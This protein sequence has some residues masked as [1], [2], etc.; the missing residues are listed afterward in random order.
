LSW[1]SKVANGYSWAVN[2]LFTDGVN[3]TAIGGDS[4]NILVQNDVVPGPYTGTGTWDTERQSVSFT[5]P[6]APNSTNTC[7]EIVFV[8]DDVTGGDQNVFIQLADVKLERGNVATP[9]VTPNRIE[10]IGKTAR[11]CLDNTTGGTSQ[12]T[13]SVVSPTS[14][15]FMLGALTKMRAQP[16]FV[17]AS[18][19]PVLQIFSSDGSSETVTPSQLASYGGDI[20]L[21]VEKSGGGNLS[22]GGGSVYLRVFNDYILDAS[23]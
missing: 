19:S 7:L 23:L 2:V 18:N 4:V 15:V 12:Q 6:S 20:R 14:A 11:Y 13:G 17:T 16:T 5:I 8:T 21:V 3:T 10:E 9:Y 1:A 22:T